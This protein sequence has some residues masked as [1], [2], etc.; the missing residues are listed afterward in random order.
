MNLTCESCSVRLNCI[1][2]PNP[3]TELYTNPY[4]PGLFYDRLLVMTMIN[5]IG[6]HMRNK[7]NVVLI[8]PEELLKL[9]LDNYWILIN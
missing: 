5:G 6:E 9:V 7:E 8:G 1:T 3:H 4:V 2:N